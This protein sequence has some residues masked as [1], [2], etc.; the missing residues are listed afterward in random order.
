VMATSLTEAPS[1]VVRGYPSAPDS[2]MTSVP[3]TRA[4][5]DFRAR[6]TGSCAVRVPGLTHVENGDAWA[7]GDKS[8]AITLLTLTAL[9]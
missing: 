2:H 7:K 9:R 1:S 3:L 4:R 6:A 5:R 8:G